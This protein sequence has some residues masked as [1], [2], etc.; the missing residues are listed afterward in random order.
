MEEN[1]GQ[2]HT[3]EPLPD[4]PA[5]PPERPRWSAAEAARRCG[6]GRATIQRALDDGRITG[7]EKT[8]DGWRIP[9][10]SLL[11]AGFK[12]TAPPKDDTSHQEQPSKGDRDHDRTPGEDARYAA[13]Q[14]EVEA[15]TRNLDHERARREQ[16][17]QRAEHAQQLAA[18]RAQHIDHLATAMRLIE[19]RTPT[20]TDT[21]SSPPEQPTGHPEQPVTKP[22]PDVTKPSAGETPAS[23]LRRCLNGT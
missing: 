17:E 8:D 5:A 19:A 1:T 21:P 11:A 3:E 9:V 6:V 10:E 16:A 12:P 23:R 14:A 2:D 22:Q 7:A 18:D 4:M 20:P 15:L 13:L